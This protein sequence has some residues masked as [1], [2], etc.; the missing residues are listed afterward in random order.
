VSIK[1]GASVFISNTT[2]NDPDG[3]SVAH[4][5]ELVQVPVSAGVS[6]G[7]NF[8]AGPD[9]TLTA[10]EAGT[11]I[12]KLYAVDNDNSPNSE[13]TQQ[14]MVAVDGPVTA[15]I[16]GDENVALASPLVLDGSGSVDADA[17]LPCSTAE[18]TC[19]HL[20]S[21]SAVVDVVGVAIYD[22]TLIDVPVEHA[23]D[24]SPGPVEYIPGVTN[25]SPSLT[26]AAG[27]LRSGSWTFQLEV[28]DDEGNRSVTTH[29]VSIL[30]PNTPPMAI[31][32]S[33][34]YVVTDAAGQ[35]STSVA[36]TGFASFD[37]DNLLAAPYSP[38]IGIARFEWQYLLAPSGCSSLPPAPMPGG[39]AQAATFILYGQGSIVPVLCQGSYLLSV[40]VTD[41]EAPPDALSNF[42]AVPLS[43]GNCPSEICI[44]YPTTANYKVVQLSDNTDAFI[45]YHLNAALY[46]NPAFAKSVR[47]ELALFHESDSTLANPVY[48]GQI[49]YDVLAASLGGSG[50]AH[51][52]GYA[53]GGKRAPAGKYTVR[54]RAGEPLQ[55]PL[56]F[57][58]VQPQAIWLEVL[59]VSIGAGTDNFLS[60]N[61]LGS[62]G[63]ALRVNYS[64]SATFT[65]GPSFDEAW[66]HIRTSANPG[67]IIGSIPISSPLSGAF[68]WTGELSP[69]LQIG[70]GTYTAEVEIRKA[71][72]SLGTSPR[73]SF[74]AYRIDVQ[75]DGT[76][77]AR[78]QSPGAVLEVNGAAKN[79]TVKL[80]PSSLSGEVLLRTSGNA[81]S[82]EVKDGA[83]AL[84]TDAGVAQP[85]NGY[86]APKVFTVK[87]L[88]G[89]AN[90]TRLEATYTPPGN[91]RGKTAQDFVNLH[92]LDVGLRP[93]CSNDAT[94]ASTGA[95]V[96]RNPA[97]LPG[98]FEQFK[99]A[100]LPIT[101][102]AQLAPG[103]SSIEVSLDYE[104][105]SAAVAALYRAEGTH[106]PVALPK[107]TWTSADFDPVT[108]KLEA[109]LLAT[110]A[111]YGEAVLRL[112]YRADGSVIAEKKL[113]VRVGDLPGLAGRPIGVVPQFLYGRVFNE[114]E[115]LRSALDPSRFG[116]RVGRKSAVYVVPHRNRAAW[117][118]NNSL[119]GAV[120]GPIEVTVGTGS[121]SANVTPL[122]TM[123]HAGDYDVI[124][125][126]GTCPLDGSFVTDGT[127]DPGD[128][129]DEI[130]VD[131][132]SVNILP[133]AVAPLPIP[134][135]SAEYG[136]AAPITTTP[137]AA[138]FDGLTS[139][140]NFRLRGKLVYPNPLP[141]G[142]LPLVVIAHGNHM[143]LQIPGL[144][145][146]PATV[147]SNENYRGYTYLQNLLAS[148][149][150]ITLSVDLD[151]M[152]GD[153]GLLPTIAGS[154]I[155]LRGNA[156][157][158]NIGE[159]LMNN[160]VAGGA[161]IGKVDPSRVY[162]LGHSRGGEAIL[163]AYALNSGTL[164]R[165]PG[166][167]AYAAGVVI[168]GL[169]SVSPVSQH[170]VVVPAT[171]PYLLLYG[172]ADGD[173]NGASPGVQPFTHVDRALGPAH[174]MY[175]IGANH[176]YFNESWAYSDAEEEPVCTV[177][178]A[179]NLT[180]TIVRLVNPVG[181]N[182]RSRTEQEDLL[183]AYALAFLM[184]Y[185]KG[186]LPWEAYFNTPPAILRPLGAP[187][188]VPIIGATK[189]A[190]GTTIVVDNYEAQPSLTKASSGATV[191]STVSGLSE[192]L[193]S[194]TNL[195]ADVGPENRFFQATTGV[196]MGWS[197]PST[198]TFTPVAPINLNG[199]TIAFRVSQQPRDPLT[200]TL[201]G[202]LDLTIAIV[203]GAGATSKIT[204]GAWATV[205]PEY[206]SNVAGVGETTKGMLES[207]SIPWWAFTANGSA[208]DLSTITSIGF[209]FGTPGTSAG[210]RVAIDDLEILR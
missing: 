54:V 198:Y 151:E 168:R 140:Y 201:G 176:N 137:V 207:R 126:F 24:F 47:L 23:A 113:K 129:S 43:I 173:V 95:F 77:A 114:A 178:A 117:A 131:A 150:Y 174:T 3:G 167:T 67:T 155:L 87:M 169:I 106:A 55:S 59:D 51:W 25:G 33:S 85:A 171:V 122:G 203:D 172:S 88:G 191:A 124:Y 152:Y 130:V 109:K 76:P 159:V 118:A 180:C 2:P 65:A 58:A 181:A 208:I 139:P 69:G 70:P 16:L 10:P 50:V 135:A 22:W 83:T 89:T 48:T 32:T 21:A 148:H 101:V 75:V 41:D 186:S 11:W 210:G 39:A 35:L 166:S 17:P 28:T 146:T 40:K 29:R 143:P 73:H 86:T 20:T 100:M 30:P 175:A 91:P 153:G 68:N 13:A 7:R 63:E 163:A 8:R 31:A 192:V 104:R 141:S 133:S 45:F 110:G 97:S 147:T 205:Y 185:D 98:N 164:A 189:S 9:L 119:A 116:D 93:F 79:L 80:E 156:I 170:A 53:N 184:R 128:I 49:D 84:A 204:I 99:L 132:P 108:K 14:V 34:G 78:K 199:A 209:E 158:R 200:I 177:T 66:L 149:G 44:D 52:H 136:V 165:P 60:L 195:A 72:R 5:W 193:L 107:T 196:V 57:E 120:V 123:L 154:G 62:G 121:T 194:D 81:G 206:R 92:G 183:K 15:K 202:P 56:F 115:A 187:L 18:P 71:G 90:P 1:S 179:G 38:G 112:Q 36:V 37:P 4:E 105:G 82:T 26:I 190:V 127:F 19:G 144:T 145:P 12:F 27:K 64:V 134:I 182:R 197:S 46:G 188:A 125:D 161:L 138:A 160:S 94:N 111:G 61:R 102:T 142:A 162:M 42:V 6:P 74:T 103:A 157:L 96:Q